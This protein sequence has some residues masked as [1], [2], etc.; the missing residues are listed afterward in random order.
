[1]DQGGE[2]YKC[3]AIRILFEKEFFFM[4][5]PSGTEVHH[6]NG[7]I[8][9]GNQTVDGGIRVMPWGVHLLI[10]FWPSAFH[11]YIHIKNAALPHCGALRSANE[12]SSGT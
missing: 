7:L 10:I 11:H 12:K 9:R 1:M 6:Q 3:Q 5:C 2:L 4:L 8:K